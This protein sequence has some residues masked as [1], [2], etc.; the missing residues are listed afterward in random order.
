M[1]GFLIGEA[2][3]DLRRGGRVGV[4]A[5]LLISISLAALGCFWLLSVNLGQAVHLWRDRVRIVAYLRAEPAAD[6]VEDLLREVAGVGGVQRVRYISKAEALASLKRSLGDQA[7]VLDQLPRNPLPASVEVT[8]DAVTATPAGAR[9]LAGRLAGLPEVEEVQGGQEWVDGLARWQHLLRVMG[10][11]VGGVFALAAILTVTTATTLVL[12]MRRQEIEVMRLVGASERVIRLPL[13]LQGMAQGL[14][15]AVLAL[16]ALAGAYAVAAPRLEPL[17][18]VTLGLQSAV[19][20]AP[21][22]MVALALG[23][24]W[25][26]AVGGLLAK[27]RPERS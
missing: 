22:E 14:A 27:G 6:A 16:G 23:G 7:E 1:L 8:P 2:L 9:A 10:L 19:F 4:T 13:L 24:A 21:G 26:G 12:H 3:R 20:F 15:G 17:L 11:A 25:L 5:V 18:N